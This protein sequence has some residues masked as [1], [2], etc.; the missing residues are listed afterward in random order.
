MIKGRTNQRST[1]GKSSEKSTS[2]AK[3]SSNNDF[4]L[5]PRMLEQLN[6]A[7]S[8]SKGKMKKKN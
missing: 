7:I 2:F 4:W 8:K 5:F 6:P 1:S 3:V